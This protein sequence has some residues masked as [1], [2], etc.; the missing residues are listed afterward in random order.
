MKCNGLPSEPLTSEV[1][2]H[3]TAGKLSDHSVAFL[4][5]QCAFLFLFFHVCVCVCVWGG[6]GGD[7]CIHSMSNEKAR[8]TCVNVPHPSLRT[9]CPGHAGV[10]EP[11]RA[12]TLGGKAPFTGGLHPGRDKVLRSLR[13]CLQA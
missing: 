3:A 4:L 8:L 9:P 12:D 13:H 2:M 11:D 5:L 1:G 6:G 7:D 10:K